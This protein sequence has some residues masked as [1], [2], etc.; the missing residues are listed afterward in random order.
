MVRNI[1]RNS[2]NFGSS[3]VKEVDLGNGNLWPT[4]DPK[5]SSKNRRAKQE[6]E[7]R[8]E[9]AHGMG[10]DLKA[11][12]PSLSNQRIKARPRHK[13]HKARRISLRSVAAVQLLTVLLCLS[14][15]SYALSIS[16]STFLPSGVVHL[17]RR[18]LL[19]KYLSL[20]RCRHAHVR[21]DSR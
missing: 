17:S 12:T 14:A 13:I 4:Q 9:M 5:K 16:G 11:N 10:Y 7:R 8:R 20:L 1:S 18:I 2:E 19:N 6:R 21:V 3:R 15:P